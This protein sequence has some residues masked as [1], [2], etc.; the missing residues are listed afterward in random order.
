MSGTPS[1]YTRTGLAG[2][3][4]S[5]F[6]SRSR[7]ARALSLVRALFRARPLARSF[8]VFSFLRFLFLYIHLSLC[9]F[10][11]CALPVSCVHLF[12]SRTHSRSL[13]LDS[14]WSS[15]SLSPPSHCHIVY[16]SLCPLTFPVAFISRPLSRFLLLVTVSFSV[17]EALD[18]S[19]S[20][21]HSHPTFDNFAIFLISLRPPY[22]SQI[23]TNLPVS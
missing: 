20:S 9:R 8:S 10:P 3:S 16:L 13:F 5:S 1:V 15:L 2:I 17:C 19:W 18:F 14:A 4:L 22:F 12:I 21:C 11:C 6:L 23:Q 7:F